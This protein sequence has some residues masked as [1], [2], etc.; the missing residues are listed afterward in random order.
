MGHR[1]LKT[2]TRTISHFNYLAGQPFPLSRLINTTDN[3]QQQGPP[4]TSGPAL[5]SRQSSAVTDKV[6]RLLTLSRVCSW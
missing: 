3:E 6:N 4:V 2:F 5:S 1:P